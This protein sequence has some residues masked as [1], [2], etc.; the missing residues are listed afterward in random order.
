MFKEAL[1]FIVQLREFL[2]KLFAE[3]AAFVFGFVPRQ[4]FKQE[5]ILTCFYYLTNKSDALR[6]KKAVRH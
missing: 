2:N 5:L 6:T 4:I 1:S 3:T